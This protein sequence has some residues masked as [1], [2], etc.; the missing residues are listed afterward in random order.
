MRRVS[1]G[2][3]NSIKPINPCKYVASW[4]AKLPRSS[5][6]CPGNKIMDLIWFILN[7]LPVSFCSLMW[8]FSIRWSKYLP[9][10]N[11]VSYLSYIVCQYCRL[12][13]GFFLGLIVFLTRWRWRGVLMKYWYW[14]LPLWGYILWIHTNLFCLSVSF[15]VESVFVYRVCILLQSVPL[16][17]SQKRHEDFPSKLARI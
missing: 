15:L 2:S 16:N 1:T 9:R 3:R 14:N 13:P 7:F 17:L 8:Y 4:C 11:A 10:D 5:I 6:H 12:I